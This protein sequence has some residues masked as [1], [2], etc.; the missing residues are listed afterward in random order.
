MFA[1]LEFVKC[2][3][4][5]FSVAII[6]ESV[7]PQYDNRLFIDLQLLT[8]KNTSSEHVVYKNCFLSW[9]CG[10]TDIR[11]N[12]SEKDLPCIEKRTEAEIKIDNS[13]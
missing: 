13:Q 2:A 4:K 1:V 5:S 9:H 7:N 11:M 6:L 12:N 10:L 8:Q 3:G